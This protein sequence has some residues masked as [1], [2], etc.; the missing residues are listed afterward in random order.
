[1]KK[2]CF[3][4][5]AIV[6]FAICSCG[7]SKV[8]NVNNGSYTCSPYTNIVTELTINKDVYSKK[9]D[10]NDAPNRNKYEKGAKIFEYP[11]GVY[12]YEI[13]YGSDWTYLHLNYDEA[14][15]EYLPN[16]SFKIEKH[17]T[18][19]IPI[20]MI[21]DGN[22][23]FSDGEDLVFIF[24]MNTNGHVFICDG[25]T[26]DLDGKYV[27]KYAD[28]E[29]YTINESAGYLLV[30]YCMNNMSMSISEGDIDV[31]GNLLRDVESES[32]LSESSSCYLPL[33]NM[34][35]INDKIYKRK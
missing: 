33:E 1:M 24:K 28:V 6:S 14:E 3:L 7:E 25:E 17:I 34:M 20:S 2:F 31:N 30:D 32:S 16:S 8:N 23:S 27:L 4:A 13:R 11:S 26:M 15:S 21:K 12:D 35:I 18:D 10:S 29:L 19:A 9:Y 22:L 5:S